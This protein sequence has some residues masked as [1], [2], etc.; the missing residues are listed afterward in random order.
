MCVSRPWRVC[1]GSA[2]AE[3]LPVHRR[4]S[5]HSSTLCGVSLSADSHCGSLVLPSFMPEL[6]SMLKLPGWTIMSRVRRCCWRPWGRT[7]LAAVMLRAGKTS[8]WKHWCCSAIDLRCITAFYSCRTPLHAAAFSG[9]VDCIHLLLSH[10]AP[11]DIA[12]QSGRTA[13]MMAAE[14]GR[15]EALGDDSWFWCFST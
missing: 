2:G 15:A 6:V 10:D 1:G 11:V 3:R 14:K 4:Q 5:V 12:D 13:L 9:H 8:V 7:S